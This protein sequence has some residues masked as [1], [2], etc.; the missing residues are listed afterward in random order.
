VV[1]TVGGWTVCVQAHA[2][3]QRTLANS[4]FNLMVLL[5][6]PDAKAMNPFYGHSSLPALSIISAMITPAILILASGNLV[7]STLTRLARIVD[8]A[9]AL[10]ERLAEYRA[11]G[12]VEGVR[13]LTAIL[14]IYRRRSLFV[15]RALSAYYAAIG[16]FIVTS[17][18]IALDNVV[19]N[20]VPWLAVVLSVFGVLL[21]L[22]G[23]VALVVETNLASGMLARELDIIGEHGP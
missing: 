6:S 1:L 9:R 17:L 18:T 23:T 16:F 22:M 13:S 3:K 11:R 14:P 12:D 8:R 15:G 4:G 21:L 2:A 5:I 7:A 10:T 19:Q 20:V